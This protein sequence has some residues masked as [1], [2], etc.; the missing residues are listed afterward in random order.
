MSKENDIYKILENEL[1]NNKFKDGQ[2]YYSENQIMTK[3]NINR[4][5]SRNVF[6]KLE[7]ANFIKSKKAVGY[8]V[9][10]K[11]FWNKGG[12]W[13][14][15]TSGNRESK[16]YFSEEKL[17]DFFV[18][19]FNLNPNNFVSYIKIRINN[20]VVH[21]YSQIWINKQL[22]GELDL[23]KLNK[24]TLDLLKYKN[25]F[26]CSLNVIKMSNVVDKDFEIFKDINDKIIPTKYSVIQNNDFEFIQLS[27]ERYVPSSFEH[28]FIQNL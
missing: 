17:D 4:L 3:F 19:K 16:V 6:K 20:G 24:S 9:N 21:S 18:N 11:N 5:T 2:K 7:K 22:V 26:D 10:I 8:F 28:Y 12:S 14:K 13:N 15:K 23:V 25:E 27:I 1:Y